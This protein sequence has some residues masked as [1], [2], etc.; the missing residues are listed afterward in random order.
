MKAKPKTTTPPKIQQYAAMPLA[1][2]ERKERDTTEYFQVPY[3]WTDKDHENWRKEQVRARRKKEGRRIA[4]IILLI[5]AVCLTSI[6]RP[7]GGHFIV[8]PS[9]VAVAAI[10]VWGLRNKAWVHPRP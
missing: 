6:Y 3:W 2:P 4:L 1:G 8:L 7:L 5:L 9:A 10:L